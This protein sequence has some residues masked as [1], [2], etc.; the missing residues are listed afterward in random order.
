MRV[1]MPPVKVTTTPSFPKYPPDFCV[2]WQLRINSKVRVIA[3]GILRLFSILRS[4]LFRW[5]F[6][7]VAGVGPFGEAEPRKESFRVLKMLN[8]YVFFMVRVLLEF[9]FQFLQRFLWAVFHRCSWLHCTGCVLRRGVW[10][11]FQCVLRV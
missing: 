2:A 1:G 4:K 8:K 3:K 7:F 6:E 11:F 10:I 5:N 9:L